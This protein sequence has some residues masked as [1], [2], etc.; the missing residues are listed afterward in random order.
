VGLGV[1][2][3]GAIFQLDVAY[4]AIVKSGLS[5]DLDRFAAGVRYLF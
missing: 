5:T 2:P 4:Q 3:R 1:I